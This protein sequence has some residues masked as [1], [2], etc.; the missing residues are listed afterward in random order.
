MKG[1]RIDKLLV[2]LGLAGSRERARALILAGRVLVDE[3]PVTKAGAVVAAGASVRLRGDDL[4]FVSRGGLKLDGALDDLAVDVAGK[5]V[6]DVGASTGGFS[7]CCLKRGATRVFAVD[8][9]RGQL[10]WSLR[11]DPRVFCLEKQNARYLAPS[12]LPGPADLAV[13][14][15]SFISLTK[16]LEPVRE[17]LAPR[18]EVLAM[19]KPQFEVGRKRVGKGGVVRDED[20]R[21]SA[22]RSVIEFARSIG[23][24]LVGRADS[25]IAGPKGNREVFVHLTRGGDVED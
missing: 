16:V 21:E 23:L 10:D 18:G 1:T 6:L 17:C 25:R 19:V 5:V 9:G 2:D 7:D 8:V 24:E 13:I 3:A 22:V 15:V 20:D 11:G 12:M 4:P 14:D